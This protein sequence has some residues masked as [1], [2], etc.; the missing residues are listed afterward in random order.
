MAEAESQKAKFQRIGRHLEGG[1]IV[2]MTSSDAIYLPVGCIHI[3]FTLH[4]GFLFGKD[5][6]TSK[7]ATP[8]SKLIVAGLDQFRNR[9]D[10]TVCFRLFF[11]AVQIALAHNQVEIGLKAWLDAWER[12]RYWADDVSQMRSKARKIWDEFF[13]KEPYPRKVV[14]PCGRM[15]SEEQLSTHFRAEH[16][17]SRS[18][19]NGTLSARN[20]RSATSGSNDSKTNKRKRIL[21]G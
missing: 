2:K 12:T 18:V 13:S 20:T 15:K 4:G 5:F 1:V 19:E 10:Q 14:C 16:F 21:D 17:W 3:V 7:S 9:Q 8:L 11:E 6:T